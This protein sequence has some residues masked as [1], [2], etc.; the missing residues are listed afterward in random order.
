MKSSCRYNVAA[1][2][3]SHNGEVVAIACNRQ[4]FMTKGGGLHAEINVLKKCKVEG[5]ARIVLLRTGKGGELR[6]IHPCK[7]CIKLL[8]KLGIK[9]EIVS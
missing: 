5:I 6:P 2:A 8:H 9:V 4:R 3:I 1:A 7:S